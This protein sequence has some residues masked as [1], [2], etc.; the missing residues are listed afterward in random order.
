[1]S[2]LISLHPHCPVCGESLLDESQLVDNCP[3]VALK[4]NSDEVQGMLYLS[5]VWDSYNYISD[6]EIKKDSIVEMLCPH[7]NSKITSKSNA[8]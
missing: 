5:S 4:I 1:M 3:S 7:C 2:E 6:L 8:L